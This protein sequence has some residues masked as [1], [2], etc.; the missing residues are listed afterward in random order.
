MLR[1]LFIEWNLIKLGGQAQG[2]VTKLYT[3]L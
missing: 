1:Y 2:I 3:Q